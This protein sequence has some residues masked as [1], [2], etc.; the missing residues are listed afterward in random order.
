MSRLLA[1]LSV[2]LV[3]SGCGGDPP[4]AAPPEPS[5][6]QS[7]TEAA[8]PVMPAEATEDS[9][10]G[11]EAFVKH[12]A[13]LVNHAQATGDTR[14]LAAAEGGACSS[15]AR[16]REGVESLYRTGGH[17]IGGAWRIR[18]TSMRRSTVLDGWNATAVVTYSKQV[19]H[20]AAGHTQKVNQAGQM[21]VTLFI[22]QRKNE[23]RVNEWLRT[24]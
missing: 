14:K 2:L 15:C 10:A 13:T 20:L 5:P 8:A 9:K 4:P 19:V 3:L 6:S 21:S 12:Y 11:A 7:E 23:W 22:E 1:V 24:A 16:A 18:I 17:L